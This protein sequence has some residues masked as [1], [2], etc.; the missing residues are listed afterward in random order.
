[1]TD[2]VDKLLAEAM[3]LPRAAR[4]ALAGRLLESL[5]PGG[6][7]QAEEAWASEIASRLSE[8]DRGAVQPIPWSIARQAI[9]ASGDD[10]AAR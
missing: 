4:A 8:L 9:M 6:D 1:M 2:D 5:E 3:R 7:E 10:P